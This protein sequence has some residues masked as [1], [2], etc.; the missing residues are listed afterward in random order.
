MDYLHD[1]GDIHKYDNVMSRKIWGNHP[2]APK[3][4]IMIPTYK[5]PELLGKSLASAVNQ[6]DFENYEIIVVDN[7]AD[8]KSDENMTLRV[9]EGFSSEKIVYYKNDCNIGIYGNTLRAAQLS[10]GKYVVLL[11]DD[12]LL[13]PQYLKIIDA[14]IEKYDYKGIVGTRPCEFRDDNFV[15]PQIKDRVYS[16]NVS[17]REFFFGCTV[18]SPGM[19]YPKAILNDI[20]NAYEELLMGDQIIQYKSLEKYGLTFINFPLAAYRIAENATL[21]DDVLCDMIYHMC[22]FRRQTAKRDLMLRFFMKIFGNEYCYWYIDSTL[23]FWKKRRLR[24]RVLE[25]MN[26]IGMQ[27]WS[28]KMILLS[29]IIGAVHDGYSKMHK[30]DCDYVEMRI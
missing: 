29:E 16:F 21:K 3:Y 11:N 14:F 30:K 8:V 1:G 13:H 22:S 27:K 5:R 6:K 25:K 28:L 10:K 26:L 23:Y 20:Y 19:M 18:T 24:R 17:K 2:K 12:D 7:D 9:I 15:F 4:S